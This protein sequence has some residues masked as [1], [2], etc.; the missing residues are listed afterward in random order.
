M[1]E[2]ALAVQS[3]NGNESSLQASV[4]CIVALLGSLQT[5][6]S[7]EINED[8]ISDQVT[9][10]QIVYKKSFLHII[11]L[12]SQIVEVINSRYSNLRESDYTGPLTYQSM[13]RLPAPY[14]DA[15]AELRQNGFETSSGSESDIEHHQESDMASNGSGQTEGPEEELPS[16]SDD[17]SSK[18]ENLWPYSHLEAPAL[19]VRTDTTDNDR[20][21][22]KEFAK[23]LKND[24]VPKLLCLRSCVEVDEA[25]QE[26]A[27]AVCQENSLNY[28]DFE[29]NVTA[30]NADGI[31]LTIYS[32]LLLSLQLMKSGYY[33]DAEKTILIPMSEQ[34]FVTSVQN[35]GVLVYLSTPWL[36]E[37]YQSI[38]VS[39][40]L[41]SLDYEDQYSNRSALVDMLCDAGGLGSTQMLSEWQRLQ[42][43]VRFNED[44][45]D[46]REAA[47]KLCR[48][49]LTCCWES[50]VTIFSTGLG[51]FN[52]SGTNRLMALSKRTLRVKIKNNKNNGEALYAMC[53]DGLHSA[54]T[55][56]N[57]LNLQHLAGKILNLLA[58]NVSQTS[59]PKIT[60][61]QAMSMDVVLN[62]GLNLGSYSSECWHSIFAVCRHVTQL[63]HDIFS[64]QNPSITTSPTS[65]RRDFE[66][67]EKLS[68][69]NTGNDKLNI[70]SIPID[71]DETW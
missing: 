51:D 6:C 48:R 62:G 41:E 60:A 70:S 33:E 2:C 66:S 18:V 43:V 56:S 4:E 20:Q 63:E 49:L 40:P 55:L 30:I 31:Y 9:L 16:S 57:S 25:M 21:H 64:L 58:A 65:N 32:A 54:A 46:R 22:A 59:G 44:H 23:A 7:G 35:A 1:E 29:Y 38:L 37:L 19:P 14:R 53:L 17:G 12:F 26:F 61:S 36:C 47:K 50:M 5:L 68:S 45:N 24:L 52:G 3:G 13:T 67:G 8:I 42:S 34:Q 10:Q 11:Y 39:N 69:N 28:S 27:S 15:V 71:E